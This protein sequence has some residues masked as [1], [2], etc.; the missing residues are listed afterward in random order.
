MFCA[1]RKL[2]QSLWDIEIEFAC[3]SI[4][5]TYMPFIL[6]ILLAFDFVG[7]FGFFHPL[8][9]GQWPDF[10]GFLSRFYPLH[11]CP[12]VILEKEPVFCFWMLSAKQYHFYN[13]FGMTRSLTG[14]VPGTSRTRSQHSTTRLS[15]RWF[16]YIIK[17]HH[18][19]CF[20]G[21]CMLTADLGQK[22]TS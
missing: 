22:T 15:R 13:V 18:Y 9:N 1:L 2:V 5:Y 21:T 6:I 12:I 19:L 16:I 4:C 11:F 20:V 10:E 3:V 17:Q 8:H 14:I 7:S